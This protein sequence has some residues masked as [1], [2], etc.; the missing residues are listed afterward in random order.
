MPS[1]GK[2]PSTPSTDVSVRSE[3]ASVRD[4]R[5]RTSSLFS[6]RSLFR[7]SSVNP[8][9]SRFQDHFSL[10]APTS[11]VKFHDSKSAARVIYNESSQLVIEEHFDEGTQAR[12]ITL[13][14]MAEEAGG[15]LQLLRFSYCLV[16]AFFLGFLFTFS[17][18]IMYFIALDFSINIDLE[19]EDL[20]FGVGCFL[21]FPILVH[22][23]AL[24]MMLGVVF[25]GDLWSGMLFCSTCE[26]LLRLLI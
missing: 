26:R 3:E 25:L 5:K 20:F 6:R 4:K 19:R 10:Q 12:A 8:Q 1:N 23:F 2:V 15:S 7:R 16:T 14:Q 13:K 24:L 18:Q 17:F 11:F 9:V 21:S 22:G